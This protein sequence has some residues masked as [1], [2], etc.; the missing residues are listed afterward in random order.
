MK[1]SE[2]RNKFN[3]ERNAENWSDWKQQWNYCSNFLKE[4]KTSY[5]NDFNVE[6][7]PENKR[8]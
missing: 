4:S 5:F 2:L 1:R 8:F 7:V 6:P 3:K